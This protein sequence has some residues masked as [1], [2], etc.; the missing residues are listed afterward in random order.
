[1]IFLNGSELERNSAG[2]QQV[3]GSAGAQGT[4]YADD[5]GAAHA[6]DDFSDF[7]AQRK[8]YFEE[9][10]AKQS[11]F[12][13]VKENEEEP[14]DSQL[15]EEI[16]SKRSAQTEHAQAK[17][18]PEPEPAS[19]DEQRAAPLSEHAQQPP[20]Q[21]DRAPSQTAKTALMTLKV[22][23]RDFP[24]YEYDDLKALA[25]KGFHYTQSMQQLA[26]HR[27]TLVELGK[28]RDIIEELDR[29]RRGLPP[30]PLQQSGDAGGSHPQ[31]RA[32]QTQ[33]SGDVREAAQ[34]AVAAMLSDEDIPKMRDDETHEEW[35][36]RSFKAF[37]E[38]LPTFIEQQAAR[39]AE[40]KA[41]QATTMK[42]GEAEETQRRQ[43]V[44]NTLK[45]DP[46]FQPTVAVIKHLAENNQISKRHLMAADE[47]EESFLLLYKDTRDKVQAYFAQQQAQAAQQ[48]RPAQPVAPS[49]VAVQP[50]GDR[51]ASNIVQFP[52]QQR[53]AAQRSAQTPALAPV[54]APYTEGTGTRV[55]PASKKPD[56]IDALDD[57]NKSEFFGLLEKVKAGLV[58]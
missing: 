31:S 14:D 45:A 47:D 8:A 15:V 58:K 7:E 19:G 48:A 37:A 26:P 56:F 13:G 9:Q 38:K 52:Q 22:E 12:G 53:Q 36:K 42:F 3:D 28:H 35:V 2:A 49:P 44:M 57:M 29:R 40:E 30:S 33:P 11:V 27:D 39:I 1:M 16:L 17:Q 34:Q 10:T 4:V 55:A 32:S 23:G 5:S 20:V 41:I 18:T 25:Q 43:R 46:L 50:Q 51:P 24:V 54:P 21:P 6:D